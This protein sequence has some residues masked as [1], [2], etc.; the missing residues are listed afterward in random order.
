[1]PEITIDD[2]KYN[3]EELSDKAQKSLVSLQFVT[4]EIQKLE[5]Q[6]SVFKTAQAAYSQ[7]LKSQL[8]E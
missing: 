6:I 7:A 3:S 4:S 8:E 1:M 2:K 5:A